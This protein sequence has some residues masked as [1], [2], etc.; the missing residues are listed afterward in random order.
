MQA[1]GDKYAYAR[2]ME[3]RLR[4]KFTARGLELYDF[5]DLAT[6]GS[7]DSEA[8]DGYHPAERAYLRML[9]A[10]LEKGSHLNAD[11]DLPRLRKTLQNAQTSC[12]FPVEPE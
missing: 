10:M 8:I 9:I 3:Q 11:A 6:T 4:E 12:G 5:S 1:L 2:I 7:P